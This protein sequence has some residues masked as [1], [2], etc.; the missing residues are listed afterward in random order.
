MKRKVSVC[1]GVVAAVVAFSAGAEEAK[2]AEQAP[3]TPPSSDAGAEVAV[4]GPGLERAMA[5]PPLIEA[6]AAGAVAAD[7]PK[8]GAQ[9]REEAAEVHVPFSL[10]VLPG[11]STSGFATGNVVNDVSLG[12]LATHAKRVNALGIALG[13]NWVRAEA[14]GALLAVGLNVVGGPST[15]THLAVGANVARADFGGLQGSV[16][17]NIVRGK[18]DGAQLS[19][20]GN[21]ATGAVD[22]AQLG[23]GAN[24]AGGDMVGAQLAVGVNVASGTMNGL[25]M[26]AGL[27]VAPRMTGVQ[28]SSGVSYAGALSGG[29]I[30]IINVGGAVKGAQVGLVNVAGSVEGAQVGLVNV[31]GRTDGEAVGL[32]S[33]IGNGQANLQ[34]WSS[35]VALTNVGV[36]LGGEHL[37]TMFTL[38]FMPP[39]DGERRHYTVG[40]GLGGHIPAGRFFFDID[41]MGSSL[42]SRRLFDYE[43]EDSKHIL[44]QLRVMAGWQLARR[45]AVFGGVS[46]NTLVTWDGS[47]PWKELGIGPEWKETSG[48]TII[49]TWPGVLAGIQ[50]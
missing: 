19:V 39:V 3:V 24:I 20:G 23:V 4:E 26:A 22:G 16:G 50:I 12:L 7:A 5:P 33:L 21:V 29:Q 9:V 46:A 42:S 13:G 28:M 44:G 17:A 30:S 41:V 43:D 40:A 15:G 48:R 36:K 14:S 45:L 11:L 49:R 2:A 27:N 37:Y 18:V 32:L 10:T 35:D 1:A 34:L 8:V 6:T 38:G 25:Q 47:D 31:S